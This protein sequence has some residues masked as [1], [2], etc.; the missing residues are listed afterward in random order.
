[1]A[2]K[3]PVS[4]APEKKGKFERFWNELFTYAYDCDNFRTLFINES[5]F[6]V[7]GILVYWLFTLSFRTNSQAIVW[8]ALVLMAIAELYIVTSLFIGLTTFFLSM[9]QRKRRE[10]QGDVSRK[11]ASKPSAKPAAKQ[12]AK[13]APKAKPA[14]RKYKVNNKRF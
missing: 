9:I 13:P 14:R 6:A 11:A 2:K 5:F 12:A 8:I 4:A 10:K 1:M 7:L 3:T